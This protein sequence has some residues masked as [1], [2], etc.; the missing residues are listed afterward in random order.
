[1]KII[2]H[3]EIVTVTTYALVFDYEGSASGSGFSFPCD[4]RGQ[5]EPMRPAGEKNYQACLTGAVNGR[6]V[7]ARGIESRTHSYPE[8]AKGRCACGRVVELDS[9]TNECDCGR[10]YNMSGQLLAPREQW[11]EETGECAAD[12][13]G[14]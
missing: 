12:L 5:P 1:M 13:R 4:K 11:G 9:F 6:R 14:L 2:K 7:V 3:R 10:D 8:C